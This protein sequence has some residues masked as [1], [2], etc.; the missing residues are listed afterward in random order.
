MIA[1]VAGRPDKTGRPGKLGAKA[2]SPPAPGHGRRGNLPK[3][4]VRFALN[5]SRPS[6]ASSVA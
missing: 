2:G 4:G 5:A 1:N 3:S 6:F